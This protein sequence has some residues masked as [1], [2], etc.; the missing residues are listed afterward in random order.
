MQAMRFLSY[1]LQQDTFGNLQLWIVF[2]GNKIGEHSYQSDLSAQ[3]AFAQEWHRAQFR[4][5]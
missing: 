4:Q 2:H 5:L 1:L 3:L